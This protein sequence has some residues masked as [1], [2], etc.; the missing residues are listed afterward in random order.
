MK[1]FLIN[2]LFLAIFITAGFFILREFKK[3]GERFVYIYNNPPSVNN[4][5]FNSIYSW[6]YILDSIPNTRISTY[7]DTSQNSTLYDL[8]QQ[9][10]IVFRF[11][12]NMCTPCVDFVIDR[13]KFCIQDFKDNENI[14]FLYSDANPAQIK[15]KIVKKSWYI[16]K[17]FHQELDNLT[18]PYLF[19]FDS[20][21]RIK[22]LYIPDPAYPELLDKY[23]EI[24]REKIR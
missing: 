10:T 6:K 24:M 18:T 12:G 7:P 1:T 20:E 19:I 4:L 16:S 23:L 5:V 2:I 9:A 11:S 21:H 13:I 22:S 8:T 15:N 14:L 3:Y 17:S